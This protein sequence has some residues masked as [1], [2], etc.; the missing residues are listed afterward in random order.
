MALVHDLAGGKDCHHCRRINKSIATTEK[1][2]EAA[3]TA[4]QKA[5]YMTVIRAH[6]LAQ[7][8]P[9]GL[10]TVK[11]MKSG[12]MLDSKKSFMTLYNHE[13]TIDELQAVVSFFT[14]PSKVR[15]VRVSPLGEGKDLS[16][17]KDVLNIAKKRGRNVSQYNVYEFKTS[18]GI[19]VLK[20][21]VRV[22]NNKEFE[23]P[24]FLRKK[25]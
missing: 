22:K 2:A 4:A 12:K 21:E 11:S 19:Y 25:E 16:N 24:Y 15:F 1:K 6:E 8:R 14:K 18:N 13:K 7:K 23:I 9:G 10:R 5:L 20:T 17:P 3:T